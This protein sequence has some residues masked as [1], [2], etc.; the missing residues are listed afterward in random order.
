MKTL[1]AA[2]AASA[3][4]N[5]AQ[6]MPAAE[7]ADRWSALAA[8]DRETIAASPEL[9]VLIGAFA[10]AGRAYRAEIVAARSLGQ[11]PRACPPD[12]ITF[13][14]DDFVAAFRQ[15]PSEERIGDVEAV[16]GRILDAR[17]PCPTTA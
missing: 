6:A 4:A 2:L 11:T 14:T 16:M 17:Y 13:S 7:F 10:E 9:P 8:N 3:L 5:A 15:L 12:Q 1:L